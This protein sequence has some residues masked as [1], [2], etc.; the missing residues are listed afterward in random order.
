M[1]REKR[2]RLT[3]LGK[4]R[5]KSGLTLQELAARSGVAPKTITLAEN[6]HSLPYNSTLSKLA[7]ALSSAFEEK[8]LST[9]VEVEDLIEDETDADTNKP[10]KKSKDA[11]NVSQLALL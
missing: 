7:D 5:A 3:R 4:L 9:R 10:T 2:A 6:R 1:K 8:G 11:G